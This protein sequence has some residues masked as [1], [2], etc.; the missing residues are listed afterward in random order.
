MCVCVCI[1]ISIS[2]YIYININIY[3]RMTAWEENYSYL[4]CVCAFYDRHVW[5]YYVCANHKCVCVC[6]CVYTLC[7]YL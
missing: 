3:A 1:Y 5:V 2:I 6:V 7:M 4:L